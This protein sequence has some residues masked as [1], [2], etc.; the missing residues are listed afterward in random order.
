MSTRLKN[1]SVGAKVFGIV[2]L[3]LLSLAAIAILSVTQMMKIGS[4]I[5]A[6]AEQDIPL[7]GIITSITVH[8]LEQAIEFERGLRFGEAMGQNELAA[9]GVETAARNF[10][11][12]AEKVE[13][14]LAK[15]EGIA[16][17]AII[18][19]HSAE[20]EKEFRHVLEVLKEIHVKHGR[21]DEQV[22]E[23]FALLSGGHIQEVLEKAE[24]I[25][26]SEDELN[27]ELEKLLN[28]ISNFTAQAT[29]T[30]EELEK[31]TLQIVTASTIAVF[32]TTFGLALYLVRMVISRPL[33]EL[34]SALDSLIAGDTDIVVTVRAEDEIGKV[35]R[36]LEI[37]RGKLIENKRL[38]AEA[39][40]QKETAA[41]ERKESLL[42]MADN[43]ENTV[44]AIVEVVASAS[45]EL[46][47]SAKVLST[48]A[49]ETSAQATAVAA[50]SEQATNN[51]NT[52]A[53]ASEELSSSIRE[54]TR[55]VDQSSAITRKA[56]E[57]A[58]KT[59][60][61][62]QGM[63]QMAEKIGEV[64]SLINDIAEQTNLL[65]LNATIEAARAG[66]AG[67]GFAVVASE[68]KNLATQ[69]AKA[70]EEISSQISGMQDVTG[71]TTK[72]IE[73]ISSIVNEVN[74]I[75][76]N[77]AAAVEEQGAA[78][79]EIARNVQEAAQGTQEVSSN[80]A[81][82]TQSVGESGRAAG[83]VL[84][85]SGELSSQAEILRREVD[86]FLSEIRAA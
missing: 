12:L 52:V 47:S 85:A 57:E 15:A 33:T 6:V 83:Q 26:R 24:G 3:C 82:V 61:T 11:L 68:V 75:A 43:L 77:I 23:S 58:G 36:A 1:L 9:E 53:S 25:E 29:H 60:E 30:V 14:E 70:T 55:Q 39:E 65:A 41:R 37:F 17:E 81:G 62:V 50:A 13:Q 7:T 42:A 56:V 49:D 19:A 10:G 79:Q 63:V 64:V 74:D 73:S 18:K 72:A 67:K 84:E 21:F 44:G 35:A 78:T 86:R 8:Q 48:T 22:L 66:E 54:I 4:Q 69:T 27:H 34:V 59:T 38:E 51:V 76:T 40:E 46:Q 45:T 2:G 28:E 32:L 71:E 31:F 80:I 20:E 5:E 16:A